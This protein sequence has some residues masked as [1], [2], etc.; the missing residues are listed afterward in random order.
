MHTTEIATIK[1]IE[2]ITFSIGKAKKVHFNSL[3]PC[4]NGSTSAIFCNAVGITSYGKVAPEKISI[5]KYR[6][7][8]TVLAILVLGDIP[9]TIIPILNIDNMT[10][11]NE[12]KNFQNEPIILKSKNNVA[13]I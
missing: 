10:R 3:I 8:A 5:G 7:L 6:I 12:R 2:N 11:T 13:T 4:V 1:I 9:P